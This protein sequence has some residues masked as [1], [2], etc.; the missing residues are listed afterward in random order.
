MKKILLVNFL[1]LSLN[2]FSQGTPKITLK[3]ASEL[4]LSNL[5]VRVN[6]TGNYAT[7]TYDMQFYN[8]LDR[9]LEGDLVFPL[10]EGQSVYRFAMDLNG[11]LR[12]AVVVEKELAR[13]AYETTVRQNIDPALLE[14][15]S[16]NNYKARVYPIFPK[17]N[18]RV[19]LT[20]EEKLSTVNDKLVY[21][22][23]LGIQE[24]VG[25]FSLDIFT[26]GISIPPVI[27]SEFSKEF[28]FI[29][30]GNVI[31]ASLAKKN[32]APQNSIKVEFK[33]TSNKENILSYRDYFY[34]SIPL[35]RELRYKEKPKRISILW[36]VSLSMR[37]R[38]LNKE[39]ELL[40]KYFIYLK[41]VEVE[42]I[43]FN[44]TVNKREK[45]FV[46]NG[47]WGG[48]RKEIKTQIYDGGTNL[49]KLSALKLNPDEILLF[50]DGLTNLGVI[51]GFKKKTV[52]TINSLTSANHFLL[53]KT[54][55]DQG[56]RYI[57]LGKLDSEEAN[58]L[59]KQEV[60]QFLGFKN[61]I[62]LNEVYPQNRA[63]VTGDFVITGRYTGKRKPLIQ[64]EFGYQGKVTKVLTFNL[65]NSQ[66]SNQTK[67]LWAKEKLKYLSKEKER[68]KKEIISLAK[69]YHL[70]TDY[71]S[72]LI[73]DRIEDYVRY[74]IE[75]PKE[76]R[77][78]YKELL[79]EKEEIK[80]SA[81][82]DIE[83]RRG[84]LFDQYKEITN[85]YDLRH[86]IKKQRKK[87]TT[88]I[89]RVRYSNIN[90]ENTITKTTDS[91]S[92]HGNHVDNHIA[93]A[94][95]YSRKVVTGTVSDSSGVL[96]G[97]T[98]MIKGTDRGTETDFDGNFTINV[99]ENEVLVFSFVGC[100]TKEV[101]INSDNTVNIELEED[102]VLD[103]VVVTGLEVARESKL[104]N[105][106]I[107]QSLLGKSSGVKISQD[108][109][110]TTK[111]SI[112]GN[113]SLHQNDPMYIVDGV[114]VKKNFIEKIKPEDIDAVQVIKPFDAIKLY[115]EKARNGIVIFT[116][117]KGKETNKKEIE[118][119][120]LLI[121]QRI[122]LKAWNPKTPYLDILKKETSV[123]SAYKKYLE[124]RDYYSNSPMFYMDVADFFDQK[125][126]K[127][128]A[129][130]VLTNL[131]E[132]DL[133]NYELIK[134]L[135]YKLEYFKEYD[136]AKN[137]YKKVLELRPEEP[138]S[139]RD[140]ALAYELAGDYQNSFNLLY[141]IYNGELLLKDEDERF[142]GIESVVFV[143][144][145]R[146]V[147]QYGNKLKLSKH[148][149]KFFKTI[150]VDVRI[151]V[152]WNHNDTDIDLWV[153]DPN[154]EKAYYKNQETEIGGRMSA[155]MTE[156]YGPEEFMLKKAIKG[157]YKIMIDY[158]ADNVQKISGPTILKVNMFT[159]YGKRNEEKQTIIVKLDK[160]ED[161]IEVGKLFL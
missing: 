127:E 130:R 116:T 50:S 23:P 53:N 161:Y 44:N 67:R 49:E 2:V 32:V 129:I 16:G 112:R 11:S 3:D 135:A 147:S 64:L 33:K 100:S 102:S 151:V 59:L 31:S 10:G 106:N 62:D 150:P 41:D 99:E 157:K 86:P 60:L 12:E 69:Q 55:T 27:K 136:L 26:H 87:R 29:K 95:D 152:D 61:N 30:K 155:D 107:I 124:I 153:I 104:V 74:G 65:E 63:N 15:T 34:A 42:F 108:N 1:M 138:Q 47:E 101:M 4:K 88:Q 117:K 80:T 110:K 148:Q 45:F 21:E 78:R 83:E 92:M 7:T 66:N 77:S 131:I 9:T 76:L 71:T 109:Q 105:N 133:D 8:G 43:S 54:A 5:K 14:K 94:I 120:N 125:G 128:L 46:T 6:I 146:L 25:S 72:M 57:N 149:K 38:S 160:E 98:V 91:S 137:I 158:Y 28:N 134:A 79:K 90:Q 132:I 52:Y 58:E 126:E 119:L 89:S 24:V 37:N 13:A 96:P 20:Y 36:D 73:L 145:S 81:I 51:E 82:E 154:G 70:V 75:P 159:N 85:W 39:I 56:G 156:G 18:K 141:K 17:K 48:L 97:V 113:T 84:N 19:V 142:D 123:L 93:V 111:I 139:Y 68:N 121:E 118:K 143:E 114:S 122:E 103:E 40:N 35:K 22:L 140:L 144:L 115:G